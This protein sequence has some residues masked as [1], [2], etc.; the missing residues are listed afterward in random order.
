MNK[1]PEKNKYI[2]LPISLL[3]TFYTLLGQQLPIEDMPYPKLKQQAS[4]SRY[5]G[6]Y[7]VIFDAEQTKL[8]PGDKVNINLRITGYGLIDPRTAKLYINGSQNIFDTLNSKIR[9]GF[10]R[11]MQKTWS[12]SGI[13]TG[14]NGTIKD[15]NGLEHTVFDDLDELPID[16]KKGANKQKQP[17]ENRSNIIIA[18]SF[19]PKYD[20]V[21]KKTVPF[22]LQRYSFVVMDDVESGTYY[23]NYVFTYFNGYEWRSNQNRI[24]L[25]VIPW[26]KKYESLIQWLAAIGLM[27]AI[28]TFSH[29]IPTYWR[30]G[31]SRYKGVKKQLHKIVKRKK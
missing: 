1:I 5:P 7:H 29:S 17:N 13:T 19:M 24:E 23:L 20:S 10:G 15:L 27:I 2:F 6:S 30:A 28:V 3:L 31:V 18:E 14:F 9:L 4:F 11:G 26:Y 22:P 12:E 8:R 16:N 21:Q 25:E